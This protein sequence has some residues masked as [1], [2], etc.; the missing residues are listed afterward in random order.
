MAEELMAET[1]SFRRTFD[2]SGDIGNNERLPFIH[3]DDAEVRHEGREGIVGDLGAGGADAGDQGRLPGIRKSYQTDIGEE[4][5]LQHHRSFLTGTS[6]LRIA[7]RL[8]GRGGEPAIATATVAMPCHH[9]PLPILHQIGD[10]FPALRVADDRPDR[11][12]HL[13]RLSILAA[14]VRAATFMS[15]LGGIFPLVAKVEKGVEL[16]GGHEDHIT[17]ITAITAVGPSLRNELLTT[18]AHRSVPPLSSPHQY[19]CRIDKQV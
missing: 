5:Q 13:D 9:N 3:T 12:P 16:A 7:R 4:L 8:I 17:A 10:H 18:E 14:L 11:N 15:I 1:T 19:L 2:Q 6:P